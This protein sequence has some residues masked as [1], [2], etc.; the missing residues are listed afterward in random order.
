MLF[1]LIVDQFCL[2]LGRPLIP[3]AGMKGDCTIS[4]KDSDFMNMVMGKLGPQKVIS[5]ADI[6]VSLERMITLFCAKIYNSHYFYSDVC[7]FKLI[8]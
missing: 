3:Y 4:M 7:P 2:L 5:V 8:K 1:I 6:K